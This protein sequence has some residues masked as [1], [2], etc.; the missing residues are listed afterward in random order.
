MNT[1]AKYTKVNEN[2]ISFRSA[3][4]YSLKKDMRGKINILP[5]RDAFLTSHG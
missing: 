4:I 3:A 1:K 2:S 5:N